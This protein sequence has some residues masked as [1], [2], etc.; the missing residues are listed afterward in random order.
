MQEEKVVLV[1]EQDEELGFMNKMEAHEKGVLHRAFSVFIFND[2]G[3]TLLQKRAL[4]KYHSPGLW[5]N[6]CCSHPQKG[7]TYEEAALRRMPE[8]IGITTAITDAFW[9]IYKADVGQGLT[10]HELDH[11]FTG[12]YNENP[13]LNPGEA[14][15][16]KWMQTEAVKKDIHLHPE[17]YTEWFKI[18]F[19]KYDE[20]IQFK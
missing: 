1:N 16:W 8:E 15:D 20:Y 9:F 2:K 7:E 6:A 4:S 13:K 19:N 3:E 12:H 14:S 17:I 10:E 18:I 5:T 11:V